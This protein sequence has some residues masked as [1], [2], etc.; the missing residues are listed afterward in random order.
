MDDGDRDT[1]VT[2]NI[3]LDV[4]FYITYI[5]QHDEDESPLLSPLHQSKDKV[6]LCTRQIINP[7][8][9]FM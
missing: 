6:C 7:N 9:F 5:P 1:E 8:V 4:L 2:I 3:I